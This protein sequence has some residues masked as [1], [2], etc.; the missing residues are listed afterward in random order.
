MQDHEKALPSESIDRVNDLFESE[1]SEQVK[2]VYVNNVLLGRLLKSEKL[3]QQVCGNSREHFAASPD[4]NR[5]LVNAIIVALDAHTAMSTQ[6]LNNPTIQ[7]GLKAILL[8]YAG[9]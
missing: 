6:A 5:E 2:L 8:N 4:L 3:Q 9:L 1:L 7:D